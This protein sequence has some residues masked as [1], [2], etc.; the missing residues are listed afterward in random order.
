VKVKVLSARLFTTGQ[1]L[2]VTQT[3]DKLKIELPEH[4]PDPNVSTISLV[5]L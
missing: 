3:K 1:N 5:T 4:A 2:K